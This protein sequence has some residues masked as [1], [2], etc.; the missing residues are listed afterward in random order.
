VRKPNKRGVGSAS[1]A[2][3]AN[4]VAYLKLQRSSQRNITSD[5]SY[6][7]SVE[8]TRADRVIAV[9][10]LMAARLDGVLQ[11]RGETL[12]APSVP[13]TRRRFF[14]DFQRS[15]DSSVRAFCIPRLT[16]QSL[17]NPTVAESLA[18]T[19]AFC[20]MHDDLEV[21]D[22]VV[23]Q[24]TGSRDEYRPPRPDYVRDQAGSAWCR[25]SAGRMSWLLTFQPQAP[26]TVSANW[27][28]GGVFDVSIAVFQDRE[29]PALAEDSAV[30]GEYAFDAR[31]SEREGMLFID[32]PQ[33]FTFAGEEIY[34][35]DE[36][37]RVLFRTG[38][39]LLLSPLVTTDVPPIDDVQKLIWVRVQTVELEKSLTKVVVRV[40]PETEP[41]PEVLLGA[42]VA[43]VTPVVAIVHSGIVAVVTKQ[44]TIGP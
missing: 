27:H 37:L 3:P 10:P 43:G 25:K 12:T 20:R 18:L 23:N 26:G 40:L 30:T 5:L 32:V 16:W 28:P 11:L 41:P 19:D 21:D 34:L 15:G 14:A 22:D 29:L 9:D 13:A 42:N 24:R 4:G 33:P 38:S 36:D 31:W 8:R 7:V 17:A 2:V 35:D 44:V 39:W 6:R 1:Y